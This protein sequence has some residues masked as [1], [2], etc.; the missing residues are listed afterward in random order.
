[1]I[2]DRIRDGIVLVRGSRKA[3][4]IAVLVVLAILYVIFGG[5]GTRRREV[6]R[7]KNSTTS[8][9]APAVSSQEVAQDILTRFKS[10]LDTIKKQTTEQ[11][12]EIKTQR[13]AITDYEQRTAEILKKMLERMSEVSAAEQSAQPSTAPSVTTEAT[14][15]DGNP[16][17]TF[18]EDAVVAPPPP[19][20]EAKNIAFV[21]AGDSVRVKL[22]AGVN[23]PTDGTPYPVVLKLLSDVHGPDNSTLP[24][25]E[26]R[27]IA[28]AQGSLIDSRVLFRL[29][30]LNIQLPSGERKVY[31]VDGW[32]VGEDGIRGLS[33]VLIDPLGRVLAGSLAAGVIS[34]AGAGLSAANQQLVV[35]PNTGAVSTIVN[36]DLG[37]FALG[38][39]LVRAGNRWSQ[40]IQQRLSQLIPAVKV[41]SGREATAVFARSL[42][43]EGLME[44]LKVGASDSSSV[45]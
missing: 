6:V 31:D 5:G 16:L 8:Q 38:Q 14:D 21:G 27:V 26:A 7:P 18:G 44:A 45:D 33:G 43:V 35:Q 40:L 36:G 20:P 13:Q 34:G 39:G 3:Q 10:E 42:P 29:T 4:F 25:G 23:A 15:D 1:M 12:N 24:L 37:E 22:L 30:T 11:Q 9:T 2:V 28:A 19:P 17:E 41:Y 32:I